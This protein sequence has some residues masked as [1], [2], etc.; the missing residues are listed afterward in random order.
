MCLIFL[1]LFCLFVASAAQKRGS[2]E[3]FLSRPI[4]NEA[5]E[6]TGNALVEYVNK[7]QQFFQTEISSLT[8]SD[9][10]ARLMSE[11]Y[12]TQPNLNRNELMTGLLDVEIP[13]NFD[14]RERWSQCDSIRTIRDQSHCGSCWAVSA[15]ETM[16]D[17]TCIHSDGKLMSVNMC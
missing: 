15:A 1:N 11:E 14:A 6:L 4:P 10:K 8:S 5:H 7:R 13:E 17:R 12:L 9:H 2:I 3:E 16:S